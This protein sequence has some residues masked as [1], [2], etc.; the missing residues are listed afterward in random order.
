MA[1]RTLAEFGSD[2]RAFQVQNAFRRCAYVEDGVYSMNLAGLSAAL[3]A[4][5]KPDLGFAVRQPIAHFGSVDREP[6]NFRTFVQIVGELEV[7]VTWVQHVSY[8]AE[9]QKAL[10]LEIQFLVQT[11]GDNGEPNQRVP[12]DEYEKLFYEMYTD[13]AFYQVVPKIREHKTFDNGTI[14]FGQLLSL[15]RGR[16]RGMSGILPVQK[17]IDENFDILRSVLTGCEHLHLL[18]HIEICFRRLCEYSQKMNTRFATPYITAVIKKFQRANGIE[19]ALDTEDY[20]QFIDYKLS[21]CQLCLDP[22]LGLNVSSGL[23]DIYNL[24]RFDLPV[25]GETLYRAPPVRTPPQFPEEVSESED[26]D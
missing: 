21:S 1:E 20:T 11:G 7:Y 5:F 18:C 9:Q 2:H 16:N 26:S 17:K 4:L 6:V 24:E 12:T 22:A 8:V 19:D 23:S 14:D 10:F 15:I 3:N 13:E 25:N